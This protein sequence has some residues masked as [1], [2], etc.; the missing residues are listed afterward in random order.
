VALASQRRYSLSAPTERGGSGCPATFPAA[1]ALFCAARSGPSRL[2]GRSG[3]S[4]RSFRPRGLPCGSGALGGGAARGRS[5][6]LLRQRRARDC[7]PRLA[8]EGPR[9]GARD[10]RPAAG[11]ALVLSRLISVFGA[12]AGARLGLALCRRAQRNPGAP[13][14]GEADGD[15]LLGRSGA[16]LAAADFVRSPRARTLPLACWAPYPHACRAGLFQPSVS[17]A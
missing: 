11:L 8:L 17:P 3:A 1:H 4:G 7:A 10:P 13:G 14:L 15:G 9:Y 16:V 12:L 6:G 2:A 5:F